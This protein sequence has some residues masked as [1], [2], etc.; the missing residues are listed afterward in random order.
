MAT[1]IHDRLIAGVKSV[2]KDAAHPGLQFRATNRADWAPIAGDAS[3]HPDRPELLTYSEDDK[4]EALPN[5]GTLKVVDGGTALKGGWQVQAMG[6][7]WSVM[8]MSIHNGKRLYRC[9]RSVPE[10]MGG[11]NRG[12]GR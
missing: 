4:A 1:S 3:W 11:P 8:G 6:Q 5:T 9:K 7:T 10:G 2:L 12:G